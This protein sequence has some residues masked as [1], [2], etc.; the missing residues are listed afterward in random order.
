[1]HLSSIAIFFAGLLTFTSPCVLPLVPVYL[2]MLVGAD[3]VSA[4]RGRVIGRAVAFSLGLTSIFVMLGLAATSA[5]HA[6]VAHRALLL[7]LSGALVIVFGLR[8]IGLLR[9]RVLDRDARPVLHRL[10]SFSGPFGA[11]VF[12]AGFAL[13]WSPCIGPA[14]ASVLTY[15]ASSTGSPLRGAGL[16]AIYAAGIALPLIAVAAVAPR[17]LA[18]LKSIR[19]AAPR[20]ERLGGAMMIVVG[21]LMLWNARSSMVPAPSPTALVDHDVAPASSAPCEA[22]SG[23][24][25]ALPEVEGALVETD[26]PLEGARV[27]EFVGAHCPICQRMQPVI[28]QAEATCTS[29]GV[30]ARRIDVG[31][32]GGR[33]WADRF[34]VLGTPT[35]VFLD[36]RGQE[37][38]RL[39]GE[40]PVDELR[41]AIEAAYGARCAQNS[42][43]SP[44]SSG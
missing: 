7:A 39:I 27:L 4:P 22:V 23:H 11:F 28:E 42:K 37:R 44:S 10:G 32:A 41:A 30:H 36:E 17:A 3:V 8:A 24:T 12:G 21:A 20:L 19:S 34:G 35:F 43:T 40:Q 1:M 6:L 15:A 14:L 5:G 38:A 2:A 13:G 31:T 29:L 18:F 33:A 16:L 26:L 25:C 9:L